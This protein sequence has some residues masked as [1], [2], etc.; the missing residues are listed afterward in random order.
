MALRVASRLA[1]LAVL[2][3]F[4]LVKPSRSRGD[5][6]TTVA[7]EVGPTVQVSR[8]GAERAHE[9]VFLAAHPT[10][11]R[12]LIGCSMVD[13]NRY[14]ERLLHVIAYTTEDGGA[15]WKT[16]VESGEFLGDPMCG[17]GPD[18]RA[19]FLGIGTDDENWKNVVWWMELFRSEDGGRTWGKGV[20][21]PAGDRP[22][23]A[24]DATGGSTRGLGY[25]VYSVRA[26]ALDKEGPIAT[27]R[28]GAVPILE[29]LR[30]E[31]GWK[32]WSKAAVGVTLGPSF[33]T[34]T[35]AAVLSDGSLATLWVKRFLEKNDAGETSGQAA[36]QELNMTL[37]GPR[38]DLFGRTVKVADVTAGNP[39]SATFFSLAIDSS[40]G[41]YRDRLYAAW[42]DTTTPRT[43]ILLSSSS[44]RGRTW[45]K[46]Q[47]V[48]A[49]NPSR[50][51][52]SLD[53]YMPTVAVNRD[54][55][56]GV[57]WMRRTR[58]EDEGDVHF[59]ASTDGGANWL[60]SVLVSASRGRVKGGVARARLRPEDDG[61]RPTSRPKKYF[62]GGDT[63]GLAADANGVFHA[64]WADQRSGIGQV[65]T[66]TITVGGAPR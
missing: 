66:A 36:R 38:A 53:D 50:A 18:G 34:A 52:A 2:T 12:R 49:V 19:Y 21:A 58:K 63:S 28:D 48:N 62:K 7:V 27:P 32:T 9:E 29:V 17:Y 46:P 43:Q 56:V 41:P 13:M 55:V 15:S 35:G 1:S 31:D 64:L 3:A 25:I 8:E 45:S 5:R 65:Y 59:T 51:P 40:Q 22:Y 57:T 37:A 42:A 14:G 44:D 11:P 10:D 24:F 16:A 47:M 26:T 60:P 23:L 33:P 4:S 30:S 39:Y 61:E 54:G 20:R 6:P